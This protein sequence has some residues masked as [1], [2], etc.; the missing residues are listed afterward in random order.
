MSEQPN[1][2]HPEE[3]SATTRPRAHRRLGDQ[4]LPAAVPTLDQ[5]LN[6]P[7]LAEALPRSLLAALYRQAARLEA[8]LRAILATNNQDPGSENQKHDRLLDAKKAAAKLDVSTDW[9]YERANE[10][11]FTVR[12]GGSVKFSEQGIEE[13]IRRIR[14]RGGR[15]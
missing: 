2:S 11:P 7:A 12:L 8:E 6:E 15:R 3:G 1:G 5:V 13:H 10:L 14:A 9:L 4:G